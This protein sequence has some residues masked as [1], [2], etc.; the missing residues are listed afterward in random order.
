MTT[1][2]A[3]ERAMESMRK[4]AAEAAKA[5]AA[6]AAPVTTQKG[7]MALTNKTYATTQAN[8]VSTGLKAAGEYLGAATGAVRAVAAV[9]D[10][11]KTIAQAT[12]KAD[13]IA[14][15]KA[16]LAADALDPNS[17]RARATALMREKAAETAA[18]VKAQREGTSS[19]SSSVM[20]TIKSIP[21]PVLALVG[22][23]AVRAFLG[24]KK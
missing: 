12:G 20:D 8:P 15:V 23:L 14:A 18:A 3:R 11:P 4:N 24:R 10:P 5:R 13:P 16:S 1:S 6:K 22:G 2:T 21:L 7:A 19:S 9:V 17:A